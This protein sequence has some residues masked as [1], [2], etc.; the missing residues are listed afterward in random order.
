M[1]G[2]KDKLIFTEDQ[3]EYVREH[4][5]LE[6]SL[7]KVVLD[8]DYVFGEPHS[9]TGQSINRVKIGHGR[10]NINAAKGKK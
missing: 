4:R 6:K 10:K 5:R 3:K 2:R 1:A 9:Q 7:K 8:D